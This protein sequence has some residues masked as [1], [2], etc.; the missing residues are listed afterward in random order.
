MYCAD[1]S[2][3]ADCTELVAT[4]SLGQSCDE[5]GRCSGSGAGGAGGAGAGGSGAAAGSSA[6]FMPSGGAGGGDG[7]AGGGCADVTLTLE[8]TIPTVV[9][10][11]D[12]SGSM[13]APFGAGTRWDVLYATLMDP[14]TGIVPQLQTQ[15]RFGLALYTGVGDATCP[16]TT[17]VGVALGNYAAMDAVYQP[18]VPIAETPT[19]DSITKI[20]PILS[21]VTEEGPKVIVLATD[22]EPDTCEVPNPQNGQA[23]AIAAAQAAF[24]MG[25]STYIIAVGDQV[26]EQHQQ[27]MANAGTGLPLDGSMGDAPYFPAG[28]QQALVDA[29][30]TIINGVRSCVLELNG[31]VDPTKA[32]EGEVTIDGVP[33][34]FGDP[35]GWQLNSPT[36]IEL[37]GAACEEIQMGEHVVSAKFPCGAIIP[38]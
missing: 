1:G 5:R 32:S 16:N 18:A 30:E 14:A 13:T 29:F 23:E 8:P 20:L 24:A 27:D 4:C 7:G 25:V 34:P 37:L 6:Q 3:T 17:E 19:G 2:C 26:S 15:V 22:G 9:L 10:L 12:Q 38:E 11:I 31:Q 36:E 33:V 28:N 35:D 21:A